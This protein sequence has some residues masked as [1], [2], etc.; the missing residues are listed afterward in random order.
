MGKCP[1]ALISALTTSTSTHFFGV[2]YHCSYHLDA[3]FAAYKYSAIP[4]P[5]Y[6]MLFPVSV[7]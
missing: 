6:K 3:M 7:C 2:P 5:V 1:D 4:P